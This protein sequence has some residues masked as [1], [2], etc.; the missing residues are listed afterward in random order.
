MAEYDPNLARMLVTLINA[1]E[2]E[3]SRIAKIL[4]DDVGQTMSAVGLQLDV[5]RMDLAEKVPEIATRTAE[6]QRNLES[7]IGRVRDLSNELNPAVAEKAGFQF[8]MER[9]VGRYREKF[10]GSLRLMMDL[11]ERLPVPVSSA[12]YRIADQALGNAVEHAKSSQIEVL[13]RPAQKGTVLEVRDHGKGFDVKM[14]KDHIPGLGLLLMEYYASQAN[15][16]LTIASTPE[17]GTMV[18]AFYLSSA[19]QEARRGARMK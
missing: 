18:R 4:H 17:E 13:V 8:A 16:H 5:L 2:Q 11:D 7:A 12:L 9:L 10:S 15:I 19:T 1:Q 14:V 6:I 3:L